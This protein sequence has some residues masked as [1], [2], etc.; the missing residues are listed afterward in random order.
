MTT[1]TFTVSGTWTCPADVYTVDAECRAGAG[2]GGTADTNGGGGG[3]G[4]ADSKK[5][6]IPVTPGT[7]YTVTVGT[8]GAPGAGGDSWFND[9]ATVLA[10]GGAVGGNGSAGGH[11]VGGTGGVAVGSRGYEV[12]RGQWVRHRR[13]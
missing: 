10:K 3:G 6:D 11:G 5:T 7:Q 9:A 12:L 13:G 4:G 1:E 2:S 8:G